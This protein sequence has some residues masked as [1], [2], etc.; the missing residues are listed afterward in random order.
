LV[1]D[2]RKAKGL[3]WKDLAAKLGKGK[4]WVAAWARMTFPR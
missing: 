2:A 3:Q 4:E 1:L